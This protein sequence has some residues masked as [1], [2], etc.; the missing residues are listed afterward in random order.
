MLYLDLTGGGGVPSVKVSML[1]G[2]DPCPSVECTGTQASLKTSNLFDK[3]RHE[4]GSFEKV[5]VYDTETGFP[6]GSLY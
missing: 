6:Q 1:S 3:T 2:V 5:G 4:G